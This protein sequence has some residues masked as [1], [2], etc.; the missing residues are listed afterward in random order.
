MGA[1][2][3]P[4]ASYGPPAQA[5]ARAR[6]AVSRASPTPL[7]SRAACSPRGVTVPFL[8]ALVPLPRAMPEPLAVAT[9]VVGA[10]VVGAVLG[11]ALAKARIRLQRS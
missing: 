9:L 7:R 8:A 2:R 3:F 4:S 1:F 5:E 10:A 11:Q 6:G